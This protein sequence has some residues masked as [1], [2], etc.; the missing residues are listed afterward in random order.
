MKSKRLSTATILAM[1]LKEFSRRYGFTPIDA[2][3]KCWFAMNGT[4]LC[5]AARMRFGRNVEKM[6]DENTVV[7]E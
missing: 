4:R 6:M 3:E 1:P 7:M 2:M 5:D